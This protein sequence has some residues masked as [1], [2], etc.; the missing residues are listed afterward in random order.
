MK[1]TSVLLPPKLPHNQYSPSALFI[2]WWP[3]K[4]VLSAQLRCLLLPFGD[5]N[6]VHQN[7]FLWMVELSF[8]VCTCG[9][10]T[11]GTIFLHL[12]S[13]VA[14]EERIRMRDGK[15]EIS[16][17]CNE[18][19]SGQEREKN[20]CHFTSFPL[21]LWRGTRVEWCWWPNIHLSASTYENFLSWNMSTETVTK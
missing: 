6:K 16:Q 7:D 9:E 8:T 4:A 5:F 11:S 15:D 20:L 19:K 1:S 17:T 10:Y 21:V 12:L 13:V 3:F 18:Y 2:F 14:A